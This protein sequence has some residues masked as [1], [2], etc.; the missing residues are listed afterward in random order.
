M[1]DD[2]GGMAGFDWKT[3]RY[4]SENQEVKRLTAELAALR[5]DAVG[6]PTNFE[7]GG[8]NISLA[9]WYATLHCW[10]EC[11]GMFPGANYWDGENWRSTLPICGHAGPFE[12]SKDAAAWAYAHDPEAIGVPTAQ[13]L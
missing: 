4:E 12:T 3:A 1:E 6:A 2:Y 9:G 7:W 13:K 8:N 5:K 11:E 10:D